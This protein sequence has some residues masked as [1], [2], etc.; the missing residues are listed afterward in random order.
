MSRPM[1]GEI[2]PW[3]RRVTV[4]DNEFLI[5]ERFDRELECEHTEP[6]E[7]GGLE[8]CHNEAEWTTRTPMWANETRSRW[9]TEHLLTEVDRW[10]ES[11]GEGD[12]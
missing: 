8:P 11:R 6:T 12:D 9:C 7:D 5:L 1:T 3:K 4:D 10:V 2:P